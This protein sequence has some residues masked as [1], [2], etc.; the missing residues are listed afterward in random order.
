M[1]QII[2]IDGD[3]LSPREV[4]EIAEQYGIDLHEIGYE[5][6]SSRITA[7]R[8]RQLRS[9]PRE[10]DVWSALLSGDGNENH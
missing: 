8:S 3:Y 9:S 2:I 6:G 10:S 5:H 1:T 4:M 7:E